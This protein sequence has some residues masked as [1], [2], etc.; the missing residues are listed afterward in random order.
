MLRPPCIEGQVAD[1]N[2][3]L[4][5]LD[6]SG[7][8]WYRPEPGN[9]DERI[10]ILPVTTSRMVVE[11][12]PAARDVAISKLAN[13]EIVELTSEEC[14]TF[15]V[16]FEP[17]QLIQDAIDRANMDV[18]RALAYLKRNPLD[19]S[20]FD[21]TYHSMESLL[22]QSEM[23]IDHWKGLRGRLRPYLVRAV[24]V[25]NTKNQFFAA[26]WR[27][28]VRITHSS[29]VTNTT[30]DSLRSHASIMFGANP[31][32]TV[33]APV[34][35]YLEARPAHVYTGIDTVRLGR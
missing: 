17:N 27:D 35:V 7:I 28:S 20:T 12:S 30:N 9:P 19:G 15:G 13:T 18:K 31:R 3:K 6:P 29:V 34:V 21:D 5:S 23:K 4:P 16:P 10:L 26:L 8:E 2:S 14:R 32:E 11:I 24:A 25:Y 33:K 1:G 22:A